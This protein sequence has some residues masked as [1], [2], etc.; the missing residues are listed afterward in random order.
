MDESQNRSGLFG[1]RIGQNMALAAGA[2]AVGTFVLVYGG[3]AVAV[4]AVLRRPVAGP[5]YDSL[6]T[7]LAFGLALLIVVAAIG[8]VSGGHVNPAVTIG[9]A[10]A[11]AFPWRYVP[12]Y[13]IAQIAG[14][15]VGALAT[16]V[17]FGGAARAEAN[18]A[19]TVPTGGTGVGTVVLIEALVTFIL[20]FAVV[21][22][23]TDER[24]PAG[25]APVA[26]GA[27]LAVGVLVAGPATGGSVNPARTL[28]PALVSGQFTALWAY[29]VGPVVGG[30]VAALLYQRFL[31]Q[32]DA[33]TPDAPA[34]ASTTDAPAGRP[35]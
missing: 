17:T 6:A 14:A 5:A 15:V 28:G 3:T 9:L 12:V 8:H 32:A 23:A 25:L 11:G 29:L 18:L 19:A 10:A 27:A 30:V 33:P 21:S 7:P 4:A 1:S 2:E 22:V 26:V 16:W 34:G 35:D 20:V 13:V 31:A 24:V